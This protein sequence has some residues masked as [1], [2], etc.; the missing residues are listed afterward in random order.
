MSA[1]NRSLRY[2]P[3][4]GDIVAFSPERGTLRRK[5]LMIDGGD[6]IYRLPGGCVGSMSLSTWAEKRE[7]IAVDKLNGN[8]RS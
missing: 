5:V 3:R 2:D 4:P 7:M 6:V 1:E 8:H